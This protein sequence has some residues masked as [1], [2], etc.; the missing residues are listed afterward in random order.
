MPR[1]KPPVNA[2]SEMAIAYINHLTKPGIVLDPKEAKFVGDMHARV[3]ECEVPVFTH[4]EFL[5]LIRI[6]CEQM[7]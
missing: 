1:S 4:K 6:Y 3:T 5:Y 2:K 7:P